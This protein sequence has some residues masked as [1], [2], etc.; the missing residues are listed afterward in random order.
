MLAQGLEPIQPDQPVYE[1]A[2]NRTT[3]ELRRRRRLS[4]SIRVSLGLVLAAILPL[5]IMVAFS[6]IQSRPALITQANTA[7][8]SDAKTRVQ[9]IDTYFNERLLDTETITQVTS[10]QQFLAATPDPKS[11]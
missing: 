10:I 4:L 8:A 1:P 6:E 11:P 7:M 5:L 2:L 9:L 3:P